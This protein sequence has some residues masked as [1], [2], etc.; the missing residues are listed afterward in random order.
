VK[1]ESERQVTVRRIDFDDVFTDLPS[2]F[3]AGDLVMSHEV[4]TLSSLFP[5]GEDFFVHSVRNLA[6]RLTA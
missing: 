3:M 6:D 4:A 1:A 5:D 2:H